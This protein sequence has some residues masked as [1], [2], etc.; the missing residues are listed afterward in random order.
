MAIRHTSD[1]LSNILEVDGLTERSYAFLWIYLAQLNNYLLSIEAKIDRYEFTTQLANTL[2]N[3]PHLVEPTKIALRYSL[4]PEIYISWITDSKRQGAWIEKYARQYF[5]IQPSVNN[6][7]AAPFQIPLHLTGQ[8]RGMAIVDYMTINLTSPQRIEQIAAMQN[9]WDLQKRFE[10]VFD[11][12]HDG[13][14]DKKR[15][16]FANFMTAKFVPNAPTLFNSH[17]HEDFLINLEGIFVSNNEKTAYAK[18]V[19][20]RWNQVKR[21]EQEKTIKKQCNFNLPV[22]IDEKLTKLAAKYEMSRVDVIEILIRHEAQHE[23][24]IKSW[25]QRLPRNN[26]L[27]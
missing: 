14:G 1:R 20:N 27:Q 18:E 24:S 4:I 13:D 12:M 21:R 2:I 3:N 19:R 6:T 8:R 23:T 7:P 5:S 9:T 25:L 10:E 11:W 15:R 17:D 16:L 22:A 26:P